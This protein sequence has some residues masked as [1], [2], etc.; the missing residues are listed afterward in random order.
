VATGQFALRNQTAREASLMQEQPEASDG[1]EREL[2]ELR[3]QL[4]ASE[5]RFQNVIGKNA[6][7]IVMQDGLIHFVNEAAESLFGRKADVLIGSRFGFPLVAGESSELKIL[8]PR[9]D[10]VVAEMRVVEVE[11]QG[12]PASLA[13]IRDISDRKQME[14]DLKRSNEDLEQFARVVSHDLKAPL[15]TISI[16]I[17]HTQFGRPRSMIRPPNVAR[18]A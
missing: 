10:S 13:T 16:F 2:A 11:W 4:S 18:T 15:R 14:E 12:E 1:P 6:D 5:A 9:I 17:Y 7:G 8:R 3:N